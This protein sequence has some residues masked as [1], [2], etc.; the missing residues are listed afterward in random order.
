V[1]IDA[2]RG[3]CVPRNQCL[4]VKRLW[5]ASATLTGFQYSFNIY[6]VAVRSNHYSG[7]V[8][9]GVVVCAQVLE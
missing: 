9:G 8:Y 3:S 6:R 7:R 2:A 4:A 5:E 1:L